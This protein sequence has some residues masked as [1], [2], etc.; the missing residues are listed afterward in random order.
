[1]STEMCSPS[2]ARYQAMQA[3]AI[4]ATLERTMERL[5]AALEGAPALPL[6]GARMGLDDARRLLQRTH[7][8]RRLV[9]QLGADVAG[10][11]IPGGYERADSA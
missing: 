10:D 3:E 7:Y 2:D 1:M 5:I 9:E 4:A 11:A 6:D 8:V